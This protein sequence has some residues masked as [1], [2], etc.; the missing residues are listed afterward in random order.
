MPEDTPNMERI[1]VYV[2]APLLAEARELAAK[3]GWKLS[4]LFRIFWVT[5][6]GTYCEGSNKRLVNKGLRAKN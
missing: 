2:P 6:Y 1:E 4:E 5:G 3:E